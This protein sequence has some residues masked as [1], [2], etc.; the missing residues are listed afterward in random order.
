MVLTA[1]SSLR[2][3]TFGG[4]RSF[5]SGKLGLD[6]H[7]ILASLTISPGAEHPL[8]VY[9]MLSL[10]R[11]SSWLSSF[12]SECICIFIELLRISSARSQVAIIR[13]THHRASRN[14]CDGSNRR[15]LEECPMITQLNLVSFHPLAFVPI[16]QSLHCEVPA[17]TMSI[18]VVTQ[19]RIPS[20]YRVTARTLPSECCFLICAR[21]AQHLWTEITCGYLQTHIYSPM[22]GRSISCIK[23]SSYDECPWIDFSG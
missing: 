19:R 16:L 20:L 21:L 5:W 11:L 9:A 15:V 13:A 1:S 8:H 6:M 22:A 10:L 2:A 17:G 12:L 7:S 3:I 23:T 14:F 4:Y 18:D